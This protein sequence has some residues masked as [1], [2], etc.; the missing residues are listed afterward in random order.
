MERI[1]LVGDENGGEPRF[2]LWGA[3]VKKWAKGEAPRPNTV[4]ELVEQC[5]AAGVNIKV[6]KRYYANPVKFAQAD[7]NTVLIRLPP[8]ALL[9]ASEEGLKKD[10]MTYA[11]PPFYKRIFQNVNPVIRQG[12]KMKVHAERIGDYSMANCA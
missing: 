2:D 6:P 7:E 3:L 4:D 5:K 8:D 9:R 12:D 10:D 11:L 1:E